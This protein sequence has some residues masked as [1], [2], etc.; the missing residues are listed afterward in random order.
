MRKGKSVKQKRVAAANKNSMSDMDALFES[1]INSK[2]AEGRAEST[3]DKYRLYYR[4]FGEYLDDKGIDRDVRIISTK[5]IRDYVAWMLE[6]RVKFAGH[7][8]K[9]DKAKTLGLSPCSV[10][11]RLKS[12]KTIFRFFESENVIESNPAQSIKYVREVDEDV[13]ILTTDELRALLNAPDQRKYS[14]FRDYVLMTLLIDSFMRINE[15]TSIKQFD[16]DFS[17]Q[18]VTVRAVVAKS[19]KTRIIPL[20]KKTVS[21]LREL[22]KET[23][24]FESDYVFLANYGE[25]LQPN[26]FR[27]QLRKYA[28][29]AGID[30]RVHPHLFRHT[31]ATMALEAG[32]DIRHLQMLMGHSDLRMLIRYT[33]LSQKSL[34]KQHADFSP[35]NEVLGKLNKDRKIKR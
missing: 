35:L 2:I 21:L 30:R 17:A 4:F 3:V 20:Q 18:I 26:H 8:Y 7:K 31:G 33:H 27:N 32:M 1:F 29:R 14:D 34:K 23:E 19:R 15:A 6:D 25:R 10:N 5:V 13:Q 12:L 28:K 24:E 11:D 16:V 22:L 9:P